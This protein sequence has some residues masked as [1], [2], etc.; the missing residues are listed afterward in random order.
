MDA[1]DVG[2]AA[3]LGAGEAQQ[4]DDVGVVRVEELPRVR[5]VDPHLVDRCAVLAQVLHVA[6]DVPAPVLRHRVPDVRPQPEVRHPGLV[7]APF[8][9]GE[10][11]VQDEALAVEEFV[12]HRLQAG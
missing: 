7:D 3:L 5:P 1:G 4:A 10:S 12:A 2:L 11:L 9:H 6:Q 8:G